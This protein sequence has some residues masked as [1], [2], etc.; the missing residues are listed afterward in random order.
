MR[1]LYSV[2]GHVS[3]N[4]IKVFIVSMETQQ[5]LFALLSRYIIICAVSTM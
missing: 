5:F 3:V 4:N 2:D 1:S